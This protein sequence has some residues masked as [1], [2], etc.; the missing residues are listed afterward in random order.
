MPMNDDLS[1]MPEEKVDH[2]EG[3]ATSRSSDLA[4][5]DNAAQVLEHSN[6]RILLTPE[7]NKHVLRLI[8]LRVL[9]V[10]LFIYF[11]QALDKVSSIH[12]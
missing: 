4:L 8:D 10:I 1:K 9:P 12:G 6:Q 2:Y 3:E 11:L 5:K 7:N